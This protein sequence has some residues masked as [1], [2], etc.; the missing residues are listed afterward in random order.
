MFVISP[1][2][3]HAR[4]VRIAANVAVWS[5]STEPAIVAALTTA[6]RAAAMQ[7]PPRFEVLPTTLR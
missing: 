2:I 7:Q 1:L 3:D 4:L 5:I 6:A